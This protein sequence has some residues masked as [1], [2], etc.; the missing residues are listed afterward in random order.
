MKILTFERDTYR[1]HI[2]RARMSSG[3]RYLLTYPGRRTMY[4]IR[5]VCWL[6]YSSFQFGAEKQRYVEFIALLIRSDKENANDEDDSANF[7]HGRH[8]SFR[9]S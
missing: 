9:A 2:Y 7:S 8:L 3:V 4:V 5:W 1:K 6:T